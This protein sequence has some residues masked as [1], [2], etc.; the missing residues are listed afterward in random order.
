MYRTNGIRDG[1]P[2]RA[3]GSRNCGSTRRSHARPGR[4]GKPTIGGSAVGS[5][6][7]RSMLTRDASPNMHHACWKLESRV[8]LTV[9]ARF[10]AGASEKGWQQ[11]LVGVLCYDED[12]EKRSRTRVARSGSAREYA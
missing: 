8:H 10:G 3:E 2:A 6:T 9:Q 1:P 5:T 11:Y 7:G 4:L 12:Y